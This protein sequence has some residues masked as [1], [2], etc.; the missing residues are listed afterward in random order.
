[1]KQRNIVQIVKMMLCVQGDG[2]CKFGRRISNRGCFQGNI[3]REALQLCYFLFLALT[4]FV[5]NLDYDLTDVFLIPLRQS[6]KG[7]P[8]SRPNTYHVR[9]CFL[10]IFEVPDLLVH[11]RLDIICFDGL[12]H[13][14]H[15]LSA[16]SEDTTDRA[17]VAQNIQK[18]RCALADSTPQEA[19][20]ADDAFNLDGFERLR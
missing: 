9:H 12:I 17:D 18:A 20:D 14:F 5:A 7:G 13:V 6:A 1:M 16:P 4:L 2:Q 19:D 15:L 10:D 8:R 11:E 3:T